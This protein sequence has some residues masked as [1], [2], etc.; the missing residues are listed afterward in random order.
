MRIRYTSSEIIFAKVT[1]YMEEYDLKPKSSHSVTWV[2]LFFITEDC[3]QS[4]QSNLNVLKELCVEYHREK[5]SKWSARLN[6]CMWTLPGSP[7]TVAKRAELD[8]NRLKQ[9]DNKNG[10]PV[11]LFFYLFLIRIAFIGILSLFAS[12]Q[13]LLSL[14]LMNMGVKEVLCLGEASKRKLGSSILAT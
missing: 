5:I 10:T 11:I 8:E 2:F 4:T 13:V 1:Q 3:L 7:L 12:L 9:L 14:W 6:I